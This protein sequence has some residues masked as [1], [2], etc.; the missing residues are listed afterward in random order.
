MVRRLDHVVPDPDVP[1]VV[2]LQAVAAVAG[3]DV[4]GDDR[5]VGDLQAHPVPAVVDHLVVGDDRVVAGLVEP[6]A[7]PVVVRERVVDRPDPPGPGDLYAASAP[8]PPALLDLRHRQLLVVH[9]L[10]GF[11]SALPPA[12][13]SPGS[14]APAPTARGCDRYPSPRSLPHAI[15]RASVTAS[16]F[17]LISW[18]SYRCDSGRFFT[19]GAS[20]ARFFAR[21]AHPPVCGLH[22]VAAWPPRYPACRSPTGRTASPASDRFPAPLP[23]L[24]RPPARPPIPYGRLRLLVVSLPLGGVVATLTHRQVILHRLILDRCPRSSLRRC[25]RCSSSFVL[26]SSSFS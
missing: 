8:R 13:S 15:L 25:A 9:R 3:H 18:A 24:N 23:L 11:L 10:D 7:R 1:A 6:Q 26:F 2:D 14:A 5:G 21:P 12:R 17:A 22:P 19:A 20:F 4:V 16:I